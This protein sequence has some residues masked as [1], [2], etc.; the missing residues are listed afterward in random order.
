MKKKS[1]S[2]FRMDTKQFYIKK[3]MLIIMIVY[4]YFIIVSFSAQPAVMSSSNSEGITEL[5]YDK[6]ISFFDRG[7][8]G[9]ENF[10]EAFEHIIR[11]C[12]HFGNFFIISLFITA[13][14]LCYKRDTAVT[15]G[16]AFSQSFIF[17]F[18][19]EIHQLFVEG[20]SCQLSDMLLDSSGAML[21]ILT[22]LIVD[23]IRRNSC[24]E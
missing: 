21:G 8:I 19:D 9:K 20:R 7:Y 23:F 5:I 11:K 2:G 15:F 17:A 16:T 10:V 14:V 3:V 18:F 6:L 13:Y 24:E 4:Y 12:A 1:L 22:F